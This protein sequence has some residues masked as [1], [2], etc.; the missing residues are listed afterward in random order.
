MWGMGINLQGHASF[1]RVED[2]TVENISSNVTAVLTPKVTGDALSATGVP[3]EADSPRKRS[4][5]IGQKKMSVKHF[6]TSL[7]EVKVQENLNLDDVFTS[8]KDRLLK[9]VLC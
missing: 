2:D 9:N 1:L 6:L 3:G 4:L 8:E 5:M 7:M